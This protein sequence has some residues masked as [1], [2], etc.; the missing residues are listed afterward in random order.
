MAETPES[1]LQSDSKISDSFTSARKRLFGENDAGIDS[2]RL[3]TCSSDEVEEIE[4]ERSTDV[5]ME[6]SQPENHLPTSNDVAELIDLSRPPPSK[7]LLAKP[8]K[9]PIKTG[10]RLGKQQCEVLLYVA[11]Q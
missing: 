7:P 3:R 5:D 6:V 8:K 10:L 1:D 9:L 4:V 11:I 2:K